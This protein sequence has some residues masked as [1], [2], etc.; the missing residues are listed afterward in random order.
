MDKVADAFLYSMYLYQ[1]FLRHSRETLILGVLGF[2]KTT[3]SFPKV[4]EEVRSLPKTCT[5]TK[6]ETALAFP[7][8]SLKTRINA[9]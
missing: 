1:L 2:L 5:L 6:A 9:S 8:P 7:S 4:V 3:R